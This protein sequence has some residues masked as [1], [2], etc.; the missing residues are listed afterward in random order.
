LAILVALH[1]SKTEPHEGAANSIGELAE[2]VDIDFFAGHAVHLEQLCF[3]ASTAT[4][5][6]W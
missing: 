5:S 2:Q 4:L 1:A 6:G 3:P